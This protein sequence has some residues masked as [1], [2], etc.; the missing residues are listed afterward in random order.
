MIRLLRH[1]IARLVKSGNLKIIGPDGKAHEFGDRTGIPVEVRINSR[2]AEWAI[3][4]DPILALP[5]SY[6]NGAVD[7]V[8]GDVLSLLRLVYSEHEPGVGTP[9]WTMRLSDA[10]RYVFRRLQQLNTMARSRDNVRRH[11]DLSGELYDLFLDEDMQYSCA[12]FETPNASLE[13]AQR[14][15]KRHLAAKLCLRRSD[16]VLDIG[17]GWGGLGLYLAEKFGTEVLGVT[18]SEEQHAVSNARARDLALEKSAR[19]QLRDYRT[20]EGPFDRIVSVGMF[21]H[22]GINHYRTFFN[23]CASLLGRDG[24][25]VLHSIGRMSGPATTSPFIRKH[26]F[27]GGYIPA[28]SEVFPAIEKSGMMVTDVEVLRLH[29]AE[30]LRNWRERFTANRDKAVEIYDE[31]F[32]RMWEFYLAGSEAAFRW[33]DLMV[34]QIQ[35]THRRDAVPLTRDYIGETEKRLVSTEKSAGGRYRE[36]AE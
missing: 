6:M 12:Y 4:L 3:A 17:S 5:E 9:V 14:A 11:Y 19:F 16:R 32:A 24:V 22:V 10:L 29:Y 33:N 31:R 28:L 21:E 23:K 36:A 35:L 26:I 7:I 15:K 8:R 13:E 30:T 20:L 18:L 27:P 34:F 25:M 2:R 1:H